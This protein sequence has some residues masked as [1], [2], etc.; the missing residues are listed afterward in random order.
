MAKFE[1]YHYNMRELSCSFGRWYNH[2]SGS[3]CEA[4]KI[5]DYKKIAVVES[6]G[7]GDVFRITNHIDHDWQENDEVVSLFGNGNN[8]STSVGD[9]VVDLE[10]SKR[11]LCASCGWDEI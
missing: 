6:D 4:P 5:E 1:V 11:Y 9:I 8:R 3:E 10:N 2:L 7:L